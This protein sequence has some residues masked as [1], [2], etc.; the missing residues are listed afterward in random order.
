M[1]FV[2]SPQAVD[3]PEKSACAYD[4]RMT[5]QTI[6]G[7]A[8]GN[9]LSLV[10]PLGL[11]DIYVGGAGDGSMKIVSSWVAENAPGS[12]YFEWT[13]GSALSEY[14]SKLPADEPINLYGH[15]YGG[16][17]AAWAALRAPRRV[18]SLTTLDPVSRFKPNFNKL[19][20]AVGTWRNVNAAPSQSDNSDGIAWL[21]K[22]GA[23]VLAVSPLVFLQPMS[24]TAILP[25]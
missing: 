21:A 12:R 15:S 19:R 23:Q 17:T 6:Y 16:D 3:L 7:Y 22:N 5:G 18:N 13:Q 10:D 2:L 8:R 20:C 25:V 11:I 9:P 1:P 14:I 4:E 24:I